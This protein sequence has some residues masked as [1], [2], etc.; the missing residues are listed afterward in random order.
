[1]KPRSALS[2]RSCTCHQDSVASEESGEL[3]AQ[4]GGVADG[5]SDL[6]APMPSIGMARNR[7]FTLTPRIHTW[8]RIITRNMRE[9][10]MREAAGLL[11]LVKDDALGQTSWSFLRHATTPSNSHA[12]KVPFALKRCDSGLGLFATRPI[13]AGE[14]LIAE[15]PLARWSIASDATSAEKHASFATLLTTLSEH[16]KERLLQLSQSSKF[17]ST[18]TLLGT[19]QTNSLPIDTESETRPGTT[20]RELMR[21]RE[22]AVFSTVCRINHS[23]QPNTHHSWNSRLGKETVH[24]IADID[25]GEEV[26]TT[27]RLEQMASLYAACSL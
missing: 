5:L 12:V 24:A 4:L 11:E 23:C 21:K 2:L 15:E 3:L 18:R 9:R 1:M 7:A 13:H 14:R 6:L 17:G 10:P 27:R 19:W 16:T 20:T 26:L 25:S 8:R 22:A